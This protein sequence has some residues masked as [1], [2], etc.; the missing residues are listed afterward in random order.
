M[1]KFLTGGGHMAEAILA[2]DWTDHPLGP[3]E[4]W[5][6][7][8]KSTVA[9]V[10][11]SRFPQCV[12]WG[13]H[14]TTIPNDAFLPILGNK[15]PALGKSFRD[16]WSEAWDTI[17]P[18]ADRAFAGEP[19]FIEDFPLVIERQAKPEKAW[20]TFCYSPVRDERGKVVGM[21]D[22]VIETTFAVLAREQTELVAQ[23]LV[24][25]VKNA[26]SVAQ[27]IAGQTLRGDL[28]LP[29]ARARLESRLQAMARTHDVLI[30][31]DWQE[32]EL[33]S[34]I[35][36]ILAPHI[37]TSERVSVSGPDLR[38]S[39][40]QALSLALAIHELATNAFKY[41]AL[42]REHGHVELHWSGGGSEPFT[43]AWCERGGPEVQPPTRRGFGSRIL[44]RMLPADFTGSSELSYHPHGLHFTLTAPAHALP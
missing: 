10:L 20:F 43:L 2:H 1:L 7:T 25:R 33:A 5:S 27:A 21:L 3:P 14:L 16:V 28:T 11:A 36:H 37:D 4:G 30:G 35:E 31:S 34:V 8:L 23:E 13:E 17:G 42:S 40:P 18:I 38:V 39:G 22:T 32:A 29:E 15:P 9:T 19:T 26:L 41:G 24:H 44:E 6:A 12:V